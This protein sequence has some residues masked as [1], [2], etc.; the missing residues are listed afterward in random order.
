M[1]S[2]AAHAMKTAMLA[3]QCDPPSL[4]QIVQ[5]TAFVVASIPH[6]PIA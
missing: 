2:M 4:M 1:R 3:I 6:Q 5:D